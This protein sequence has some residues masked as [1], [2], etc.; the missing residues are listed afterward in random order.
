REAEAGAGGDR[1]KST[2]VGGAHAFFVPP[3]FQLLPRVLPA[4]SSLDTIRSEAESA[5]R[6]SA[7]DS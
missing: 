2:W 1:G 7:S 4:V 6:R 5:H 3:L